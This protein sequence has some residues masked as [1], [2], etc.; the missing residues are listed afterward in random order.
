MGAP[1]LMDAQADQILGLL[2]ATAAWLY[3]HVTG[4]VVT[5]GGT[6]QLAGAATP[7][8]VA[9]DVSQIVDAVIQGTPHELAATAD[10]DP[11]AGDQ[12]VWN[13]L[14]GVE[15]RAWVLLSGG[16]DNDTPAI[17]VVFGAVAP[18]GEAVLPSADEA[19]TWLGHSNWSPIATFRLE[20]T[21]DTAVTLDE[22]DHT[23]R[24]SVTSFAGDLATSESEFANGGFPRVFPI[25]Q[26]PPPAK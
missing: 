4:G 5:D 12:V 9:I 17:E 19:S 15:A 24:A 26:D 11:D 18:V 3:N 10:A 22:I 23:A 13:A 14:S 16:A 20:R 2:N 25:V 7:P 21:A 6:A 8:D 1:A